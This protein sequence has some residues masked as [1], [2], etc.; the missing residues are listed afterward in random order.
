MDRIEAEIELKKLFGIDHFYDE[1][2]NAIEKL[3]RGERILLI[4]KT[5]F[6][7]SLCYQFPATQ[8]SGIT[9]IFSPLIALMRDQVKALKQKGI[10]AAFINSEQSNEDNDNVIRQA[11]DGKIK[12]LY[13]AP[14]RQENE[15]WINATINMKLSMIVVDEAHT[16]STWGH[17]FRPSFRRIIDLVKLLPTS[18]PILATTATATKRVQQDIEKQIGGNIS[19]IRGSLIRRNLMLKVIK[20]SSEDE[21]MLWLAANL[22]KIEGSGLIYTGTRVDTESYAAW[23]KHAGIDAVDYNAGLD[24][25]TR[26]HIENGLMNNKWKCVVSTNALGMGIDKPDIRFIVHTQIPASPIH[27]YQEI[28]R[29]GRDGKNSLIVLFYNDKIDSD[30]IPTD[31]RLPKSFIDNARPSE[32]LYCRVVEKL[33]A[34]P[35]SERAL[36]K[37]ANLKQTQVRVIKSD[38][39]DQKIIKEVKYGSSKKYEYQFGAPELNTE[40]FEQLRES[41][42]KELDSMV[43]YVYTQV[44][45]MKFLCNYLDSNEDSIYDNCDNT[46][47]EKE[48][49]NFSKEQEKNLEEFHLNYFPLLDTA[50]V[51]SKTVQGVKWSVLIPKPDV[52]EV[53]KEDVIYKSCLFAD[54]SKVLSEEERELLSVLIDSHKSKKSKLTNGYAASY[55]GTSNVG[56]AIHR[57]KYENGGDFPDFLL[58]QTLRAYGKNFGKTKIDMVIFVPP[59]HSGDLVKNFAAKFAST[60]RVPL[61]CELRKIRETAEQKIFQNSYSKRDNVADA[62]DIDSNI[63]KNKRII[64]IDDI[65]DSGATLEEIGKLLT[66][67]GAEYIIPMVISGKVEL[68]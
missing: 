2:W 53:R 22:N 59:T 38:L 1:Q 11:L 17:D 3:L 14:E 68:M 13:I 4:E 55:Y 21:K 27:Y 65:F 60:L 52:I 42:T 48:I 50:D 31:Y 64:L 28:G 30:G 40:K 9:V 45:R 5:G 44:P 67:K 47:L 33:K 54:I 24:P 49:L 6:G 66:T 12:I 25:E 41:K 35:M 10:S 7:K 29:A 51:T 15:E 46:T 36:M 56:T 20:V 57:C 32:K 18:F 39:I 8:F 62:F 16:V 61:C 58:K 37:A 43:S 23:L 26:K 63:V 34:E 19:T